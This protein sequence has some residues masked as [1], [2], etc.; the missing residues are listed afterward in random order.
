MGNGKFKI[1]QL[2]QLPL[3][4]GSAALALDP[5]FTSSRRTSQPPCPDES[6]QWHVLR[7]SA[8][9]SPY[10]HPLCG[11]GFTFAP[12]GHCCSMSVG[13]VFAHPRLSTYR[14]SLSYEQLSRSLS[15]WTGRWQ[16][17][18]KALISNGWQRAGDKVWP[19]KLYR[20]LELSF[21]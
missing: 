6:L 3:P 18:A 15:E 5:G 17:Y 11:V 14:H 2:A 9:H 20:I 7:A 21:G 1:T 4:P 12:S 10:P 19:Q 8:H 13:M 16:L